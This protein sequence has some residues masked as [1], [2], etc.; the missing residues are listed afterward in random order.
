M[1][2]DCLD[3]LEG[4]KQL[5][6][7]FGTDDSEAVKQ[8]YGKALLRLTGGDPQPGL[9]RIEQGWAEIVGAR[10]QQKQEH[11]NAATLLEGNSIGSSPSVLYF[12]IT[13]CCI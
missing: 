11:C 12:S 6:S 4:Q 8:H 3:S 10:K 2:L 9:G 13:A 7:R 5:R 1:V